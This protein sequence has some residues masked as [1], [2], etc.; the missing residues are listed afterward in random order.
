MKQ[1]HC[2]VTDEQ[3]DYLKNLA[4][5]VSVKKGKIVEVSEILRGIIDFYRLQNE[6][7]K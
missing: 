6:K 4:L 7:A 2:R 3:W 5:K 1:R